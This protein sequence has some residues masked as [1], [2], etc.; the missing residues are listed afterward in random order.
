MVFPVDGS[1]AEV[2][3]SYKNRTFFGECGNQHNNDEVRALVSCMFDVF[4]NFF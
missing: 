4:N 1:K 2:P 3:N